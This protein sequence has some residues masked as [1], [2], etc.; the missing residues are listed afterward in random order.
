MAAAI[1][2]RRH[3]LRVTAGAGA[4]FLTSCSEKPELTPL[5]TTPIGHDASGKL[6][7]S[8]LDDPFASGTFQHALRLGGGDSRLGKKLGKGLNARQ[9]LD[10]ASLLEPATQRTPVERFYIRTE[11]PDLLDP[12]APWRI[13]IHGHVREARELTVEQLGS[14]VR[15][16]GGALLECAGNGPGFGF[17]LLSVADWSGIPFAK[18]VELAAPT[19]KCTRVLVS[20]FDE[21]THASSYSTPGASWIFT[22]E[23]L[24]GAKAFLATEIN[25]VPLPPDHGFPIRLIVP[26]WYGC[27]DIKWV[28]E[29]KFVD[30]EE[31]STAH[32]REFAERIH[33]GG[34]PEM[35]RDFAPATIDRAATAVSVEKWLLGGKVSYRVVGI[36]WGGDGATDELEIRFSRQWS[37]GSGSFEPVSVYARRLGDRRLGDHPFGVWCHRWQPDE[38]GTYDIELRIANKSIRARRLEDSYYRRTVEI[39]DV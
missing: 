19:T 6:A 36:A 39:T 33:Q 25:G 14:A 16:Q 30:D 5:P 18:L 34:V 37:L 12:R 20:G 32:M 3:F 26:N 38:D 7:G 2:D 4:L 27:C 11:L 1:V 24:A 35:A 22:L 21:T 8:T 17:G 10:I 13:R 31:P 23:E 28:N 15:P 9:A 29:I